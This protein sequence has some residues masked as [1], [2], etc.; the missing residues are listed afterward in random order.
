MGLGNWA[1][2]IAGKVRKVSPSAL[3]IKFSGRGLRGPGLH[4][5]TRGPPFG[6]K[7]LYPE[8]GPFPLGKTLLDRISSCF[9]RW[10]GG[11]YSTHS[12]T[13]NTKTMPTP[14]LKYPMYSLMVKVSSSGISKE[15]VGAGKG[16]S[17]GIER[18][19]VSGK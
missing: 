10:D 5:T 18:G 15:G 9:R 7:S 17:V 2:G 1:L 6:R 19:V 16:D 11:L 3:S 14:K 4:L 13:K 8:A 12:K